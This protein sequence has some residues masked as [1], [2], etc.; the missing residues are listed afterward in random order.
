MQLLS[1]VLPTVDLDAVALAGV[2]R[3]AVWVDPVGWRALGVGADDRVLVS[4]HGRFTRVTDVVLHDKV[5]SVRLSQGPLQRRLGLASL[6]L[7]TTPG[8]VRATAAHRSA[9]EARA[10]LDAEV[11]LARAARAVAVPDRWM[12]PSGGLAAPTV[13][14]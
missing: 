9:V 12:R 5:Q 7:D 14:P 2:P 13:T 3:T 11:V 8:P 6:H 4:R 1:R 10:L